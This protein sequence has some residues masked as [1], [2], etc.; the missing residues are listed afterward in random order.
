MNDEFAAGFAKLIDEFSEDAAE[1]VEGRATVKSVKAASKPKHI[2][3]LARI[4]QARDFED[5]AG[6]VWMLGDDLY[7]GQVTSKT[8]SF[9]FH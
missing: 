3:E 1:H 2:P 7:V 5:R 4:I 9:L 6:D 8:L